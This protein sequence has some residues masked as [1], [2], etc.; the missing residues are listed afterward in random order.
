MAVRFPTGRGTPALQRAKAAFFDAVVK[1]VEG[2]EGDRLR[3]DLWDRFT[4]LG[5]CAA[6]VGGLPSAARNS[7][8]EYDLQNGCRSADAGLIC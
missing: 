2:E 7:A 6:G 5:R 4:E 3:N 8:D 1:T